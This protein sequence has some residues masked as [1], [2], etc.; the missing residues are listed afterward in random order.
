MIELFA[1]IRAVEH[2]LARAEQA[3]VATELV[4]KHVHTLG[5]ALQIVDL[6]SAELVRRDED[7]SDDLVAELRIAAEQARNELA[8]LVA[9]A[10]PPP[11]SS[12]GVAVAPCVRRA[13]ELVRAAVPAVALDGVLAD[14]VA[15]RLDPDELEALVL[16]AALDAAAATRIHFTLRERTIAGARWIELV[17]TD[18]RAGH[19][20]LDVAP[21][22]LA[23][24][25][26]AIARLAGGEVSLA[27]GRNGHELAI[28][29][30][31]T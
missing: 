20:E 11:R 13:V 16:A 6:A 24:V 21:P 8:K 26:D 25:V 10:H 31:V 9:L 7:D 17:R 5:N 30:P 18:N 19:V 14:S 1:R 22:S 4:R 3:R 27:P 12:R 2:R 15:A 28:A 29:L 23:G